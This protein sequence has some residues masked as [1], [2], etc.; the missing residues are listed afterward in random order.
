MRNKEIAVAAVFLMMS[1][2]CSRIW[3]HCQIPCGIYDDPARFNS[4]LENVQT[5][6]KSIKQIES[7]STEKVQNWNQLVRW[8]DNK[9][10]HADK[11]AETVTYYFMAQQIKPLDAADDAVREKYVREVTLLHEILFNSMKAKQN[12]ALKY[13]TK[14]RELILQFRQSFLGEKSH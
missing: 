2:L 1:I 14:L 10:V 9:E 11:L 7:L 13:C 3:A 5:I 12:T 6:E 8:I 4:M